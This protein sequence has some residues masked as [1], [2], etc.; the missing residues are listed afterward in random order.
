MLN[1]PS[2]EKAVDFLIFK[3]INL[4]RVDDFAARVFLTAFINYSN[5]GTA[6]EEAIVKL[7]LNR[8][9]KKLT[10]SISLEIY[11]A[12]EKIPLKMRRQHERELLEA[13]QEIKPTFFFS[14]DS[15]K[16]WVYRIF[17]GVIGI[18]QG[19]LNLFKKKSAR[20][21]AISFLG[22]KALQQHRIKLFISF[23][24]VSIFLIVLSVLQSEKKTKSTSDLLNIEPQYTS[25]D[26]KLSYSVQIAA[27]KN[28]SGAERFINKLAKKGRKA[29]YTKPSGGSSWFRVRIGEFK[30]QNEAKK[31]AEKLLK[32]KLAKG[33]FIT[34]FEPGFIKKEME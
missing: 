7:A 16:K 3:L 12:F 20:L 23:V 5:R 10:D 29:Y 4:Q 14:K 11:D 19:S 13:P 34:N 2:K 25:Y 18:I 15:V 9:K 8:K 31:F 30:T 26:S 27:F 22:K 17:Y 24:L 32:E 6:I 33:Y 21:Q 1:I 28:L